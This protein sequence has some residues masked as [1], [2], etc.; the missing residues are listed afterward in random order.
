[1]NTKLTKPAPAV[2]NWKGT[3][4]YYIKNHIEEF[5]ACK[6][7]ESLIAFLQSIPM[8][9]LNTNAQEYRE[10]LILEFQN[11]NF[12]KCIFQIWQVVLAGEGMKA[13]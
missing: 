9:S 12:K 7:K 3:L 13:I 4:G 11:K 6:D 8:D 10:R 2:N 5:N 1:M